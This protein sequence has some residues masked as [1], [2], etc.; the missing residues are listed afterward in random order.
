MWFLD[1][2]VKFHL[3]NK[4][5]GFEWAFVAVYVAAQDAKKSKLLVEL[6]WIL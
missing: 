2:Y 1:F 3:R 6:V 5:D 4:S